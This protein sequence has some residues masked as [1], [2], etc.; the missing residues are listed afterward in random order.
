[1]TTIAHPVLDGFPGLPAIDTAASRPP[2][3]PAGPLLAEVRAR[4]LCLNRFPQ[5]AH[6]AYYR[7]ARH[8]SLTLAAADH[9][10]VALLGEH[11]AAIWGDDWWEASAA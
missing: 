7:A 9:L 6:R 11:P 2:H 1:M 8:G 5:A 4:G 3:L 10:A